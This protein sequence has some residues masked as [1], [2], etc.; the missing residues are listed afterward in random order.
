MISH[1]ERRLP[2]GSSVHFEQ[3]QY[4][5][6]TSLNLKEPQARGLAWGISMTNENG[7]NVSTIVTNIG[8]SSDNDSAAFTGLMIKL[9]MSGA[10]SPGFWSGE[11][12]PPSQDIADWKLV[13][14]F[15][16]HEEARAWQSSDIR[17]SIVSE[18]R[19]LADGSQFQMAEQVATDADADVATAI[20]TEIHPG[21]EEPYYDWET[22]IQTAQAKFPGYRGSYLQPPSQGR[23]QQW[24][25]LLRFA[26][27]ETLETWF[28]SSERQ[29]LLKET[30]GFVK[31]TRM[32]TVE[33]SFPGWFPNDEATGQPPPNY[34]TGM[35][36]LLGLFPVVMLEIRYLNPLLAPLNPS[37]A[38]FI[39][40]VLSVVVT[41]YITTPAFINW[42]RWWLYPKNEA[43]AASSNIKGNLVLIA[44]FVAEILAMWQLLPHKG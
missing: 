10:R 18:M 43:E 17:N 37:L 38:S 15:R 34:K 44:L 11:I 28:N 6:L 16:T 4:A 9:L 22:R 8:I 35:L 13:Q 33:T 27:P 39:S 29:E 5:K 32:R 24:A 25:T 42:F 23:S 12:V 3:V 36:V 1:W 20:V 2:A 26:T 30:A 21:M 41:T 40:L 31:A 19:T 14:R 7:Q